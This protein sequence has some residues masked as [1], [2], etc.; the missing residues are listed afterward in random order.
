MEDYKRVAMDYMVTCMKQQDLHINYEEDNYDAGIAK[1]ISEEVPKAFTAGVEWVKEQLDW[2]C[3]K[4]RLP[5]VEPYADSSE[6]VLVIKHDGMHLLIY[7]R[8]H[9]CWDDEYGDDYEY[10][11]EETDLWKPTGFPNGYF[12]EE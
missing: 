9:E 12:A 2:V 5:D 7:N 10:S 1:A 3:A 6:P 11:I 8:T 4:D